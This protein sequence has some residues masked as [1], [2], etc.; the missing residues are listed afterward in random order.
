MPFLM[1]SLRL[2]QTSKIMLPLSGQFRGG[3]FS[4]FHAMRHLAQDEKKHMMWRLSRF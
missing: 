3:T 1:A 2:S 4:V